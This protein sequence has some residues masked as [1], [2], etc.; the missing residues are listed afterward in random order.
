[1]VMLNFLNVLLIEFS[2]FVFKSHEL[3]DELP[4]LLDLGHVLM[5]VAL[6]FKLTDLLGNRL[7]VGGQ[8]LL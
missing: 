2:F 1:M 7:I 4:L 3:F 6:E 8:L 5:G